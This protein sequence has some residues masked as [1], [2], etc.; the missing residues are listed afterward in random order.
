MKRL[1]LFAWAVISGIL[2]LFSVLTLRIASWRWIDPS[3]TT[4]MRSEAAR[5]AH[6]RVKGEREAFEFDHAWVPYA[7]INDSVKA[8]VIASEDAGFVDHEGVDWEAIQKAWEGNNKGRRIK[9][10]ST[11]TQQLAKNLFLSGERSYVRKGMELYLTYALE[12]MLDKQRILEIYLNSV[13][14]GDGVFGVEAAARQY[15]NTSATSLSSNQAARLA[16][17]LP[18]P[19]FFEQK[20][21][22]RYLLARAGVIQR[23]MSYV[24]L[25]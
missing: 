2:V 8:A 10:G 16:V 6:E 12:L 7:Q 18:R 23:R 4:F 3:S 5:I 15:F 24:D 22:S 13:E 20:Q 1:K 17:M 19:K 11:I 9:G 25:P 14:W 21:N